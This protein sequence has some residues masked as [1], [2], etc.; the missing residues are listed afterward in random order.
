MGAKDYRTGQEHRGQ[1]KQTFAEAVGARRVSVFIG[2]NRIIKSKGLVSKRRG[3]RGAA[4]LR[5]YGRSDSVGI[6]G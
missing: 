1:A 6:H 3:F 5:K 4:K 2:L